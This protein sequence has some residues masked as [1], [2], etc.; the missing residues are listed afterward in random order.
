MNDGELLVRGGLDHLRDPDDVAALV[1][2]EPQPE[3]LGRCDDVEHPAVR[4]VDG[5]GAKLG[6]LDRGREMGRE[7]G[8]VAER[9]AGDLAVGAGRPGRG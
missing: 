3:R 1:R 8:H 2:G 9:H 4:D 6:D 5:D 7:R